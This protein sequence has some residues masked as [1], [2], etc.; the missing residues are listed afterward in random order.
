MIRVNSIKCIF[1]ILLFAVCLSDGAS[2]NDH[3]IDTQTSIRE[4]NISSNRR[5]ELSGE[6]D[7]KEN[8]NNRGEVSLSEN[9]SPVVNL[10]ETKR[11]NDSSA[12]ITPLTDDHLDKLSIENGIETADAK[13]KAYPIDEIK[14]DSNSDSNFSPLLQNPPLTKEDSNEQKQTF[15]FSSL[16]KKIIF[17]C[18]VLSMLAAVFLIGLSVFYRFY[19]LKKKRVPFT[20]PLFLYFLFP[21]PVNYETEISV[22]CSKYMSD[23]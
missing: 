13:N 17:L 21:R 16:W 18:T 5:S 14:K 9:I 23:A 12:I 20:A 15:Q 6:G 19:L 3:K 4:A 11:E 2:Q 8:S 10:S 22:L 1:L 7:K